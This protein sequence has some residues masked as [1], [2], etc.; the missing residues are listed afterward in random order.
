[1]LAAARIPAP[2]AAAITQCNVMV[3]SAVRRLLNVR[4][5]A[6]L[7]PGARIACSIADAREDA[8]FTVRLHSDSTVANRLSRAF[9]RA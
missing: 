8:P 9:L 6:H 1:M 7:P 3:T 5:L 4:P 2:P